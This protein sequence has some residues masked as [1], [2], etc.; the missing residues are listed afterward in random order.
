MHSFADSQDVEVGEVEDLVLAEE[1][2]CVRAWGLVADEADDLFLSSD[3]WLE[4]GVASPDLDVVDEVRVDVGVV[5]FLHDVDVD[6]LVGV[7]ETLDEEVEFSDDVGDGAVVL[8]VFLD[9][10][11]Q[12]PCLVDLFEHH[13]ADRSLRRRLFAQPPFMFLRNVLHNKFPFTFTLPPR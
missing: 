8:E 5:E 6:E 12:Q 9:L 1:W 7:S 10:E 2:S 13:V 3:E 4:V 11:S